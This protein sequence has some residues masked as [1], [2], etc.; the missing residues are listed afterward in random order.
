MGS[1]IE[2]EMDAIR[3]IGQ[4]QGQCLGIPPKEYTL[5]LP[6]AYGGEM[7]VCDFIASLPV[8]LVWKGSSGLILC[9]DC[10]GIICLYICG[11]I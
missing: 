5:C 4:L 7:Q 1:W 8:T 3:A 9:I 11:Y 10:L 2:E 6:L